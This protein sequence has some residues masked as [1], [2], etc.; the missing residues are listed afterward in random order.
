MAES[1]ILLRRLTGVLSCNHE[2]IRSICLEQ[3]KIMQGEFFTTVVSSSSIG[4]SSWVLYQ[5][6][7]PTSDIATYH[8]QEIDINN[9]NGFTEL[10]MLESPTTFTT[11]NNQ[12]YTYNRNFNS[13]ITPY[14][15]VYNNP[16]GGSL[17]ST[18]TSTQ[19]T[20]KSYIYLGSTGQKH[21]SL[22]GNATL[23]HEMVLK[24]NTTYICKIT[25]MSTDDGYFSV[26]VH[27]YQ[28]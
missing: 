2:H 10:L 14:Y 3:C 7:T 25:N 9:S 26:R 16:T 13:T 12:I 19:C 15:T 23:G 17:S 4:G 27:L 20:K 8:I 6:N 21:S 11:G 28:E 18:A 1:N 24:H 22:P 5:I